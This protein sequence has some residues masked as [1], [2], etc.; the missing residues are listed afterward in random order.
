MRPIFTKK[1]IEKQNIYVINDSISSPWIWRLTFPNKYKYIG[2]FD[3]VAYLHGDMSANMQK[4]F[5]NFDYNLPQYLNYIKTVYNDRI[6]FSKE[7]SKQFNFP[8]ELKYYADKEIQYSYYKNLIEPISDNSK[9]LPAY[10]QHLIDTF[11]NI[12][13]NLS[14]TI[15][16]NKV[17]AYRVVVYNYVNNI[18]TDTFINKNYQ[19]NYYLDRLQYSKTYFTGEILGYILARFM[20]LAS[21]NDESKYFITLYNTYNRKSSSKGITIFV[22]SLFKLTVNDRPFTK[23]EILGLIF[24]NSQHKKVLL[25]DIITRKIILIDCWATWCMPCIEQ[26]PFMDSLA[27]MYKDKVQFVSLDVDQF[28]GKWDTWL[29]KNNQSEKSITSL[30]ALGGFDHIFLKNFRINSIPRYI[31]LTHNG[32]VLNISMPRPSDRNAF[33]TILNQYTK[34]Q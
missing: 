17:A 10:P 32:D 16:F 30:Y 4:S 13:K 34:N 2:F 9:L 26:M 20:E 3:S 25:K 6:N 14:N 33:E 31:L 12:K 8:K 22:D 5:K 19:G 1:M 7:F 11:I 18:G 15:L 24:L 29:T 23:D 27:Y 21:R 28:I